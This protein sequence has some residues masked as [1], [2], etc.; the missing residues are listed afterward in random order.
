MTLLLQ[1]AD[2]QG[3][4]A[5]ALLRLAA[6]E[7]RALYPEAFAADAPQ[8]SN[9]STPPRGVYLVGYD[10]GRP[11]AMGAHQPLDAATTEL[12]RLYVRADARRSG[13][14]RA[15]VAALE[16]HAR[17]QGFGLMR[18]ETGWRQLPA[19]RLYEACGWIRIAPFGPYA[20]DPSSV[21][22]EKRLLQATA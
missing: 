1:V 6:A 12:R 9:R 19:M 11:V 14:A 16:A 5:L 4:D 8:P 21:C 20:G 7:A 17:A 18:L 2:P 22:Y 15:V 10:D 3:A 13:V